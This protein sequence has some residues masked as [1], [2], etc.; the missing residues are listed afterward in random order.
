MFP[1]FTN[2]FFLK[3]SIHNHLEEQSE[4]DESNDIN[5]HENQI[6]NKLK[7]IKDL[8]QKIAHLEHSVKN[9]SSRN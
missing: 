9:P 5:V 8:S 3:S 2:P 1:Q 6:N 7:I 4:L